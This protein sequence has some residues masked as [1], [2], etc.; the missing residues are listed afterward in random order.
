MASNWPHGPNPVKASL[1]V[2]TAGTLGAGVVAGGVVID[3]TRA[4]LVGAGDA[5]GAGRLRGATQLVP[6]GDSVQLLLS[7]SDHVIEL[8]SLENWR[9]LVLG[10]LWEPRSYI[11][12][13]ISAGTA[14][15]LG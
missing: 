5:G 1:A 11:T 13:Q 6:S 7:S 10:G 4:G 2:L 15:V 14:A 8:S 3:V 9:H 12:T